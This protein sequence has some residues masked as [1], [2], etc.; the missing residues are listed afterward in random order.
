VPLLW[1]DGRAPWTVPAAELPLA[2][3]AQIGAFMTDLAG[4]GILGGK[5]DHSAARQSPGSGGFSGDATIELREAL[6]AHGGQ[7]WSAI[8]ALIRDVGA[9]G[10]GR[11]DTLVSVT[12]YLVRR[13][14][15]TCSI[16]EHLLPLVNEHFKDGDWTKEVRDAV[17]YAEKCQKEQLAADFDDATDDGEA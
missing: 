16:K 13:R 3:E 5:V 17:T 15:P 8:T 2:T 6:V 11:H 9:R 7:V 4:A 12:G 1:R 14:W 10:T